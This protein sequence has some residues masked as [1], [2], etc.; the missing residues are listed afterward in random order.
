MINGEQVHLTTKGAT[1]VGAIYAS[2]SKIF[3][4]KGDVH[5]GLMQGNIKVIPNLFLQIKRLLR[6]QYIYQ[7]GVA[8]ISPSFL[9]V[10]TD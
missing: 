3:T 8:N 1:D 7:L 6:R 2:D 9:I 4:E 5:I 10:M